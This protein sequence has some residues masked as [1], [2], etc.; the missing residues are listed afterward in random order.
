ML[1]IV[2][3]LDQMT[4]PGFKSSRMDGLL[5]LSSFECQR[6]AFRTGPEESQGLV[7]EKILNGELASGI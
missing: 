4:L 2:C 5:A 1:A 6:G 7:P 3:F